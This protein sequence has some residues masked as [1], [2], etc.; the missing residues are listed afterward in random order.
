MRYI[1]GIQFDPRYLIDTHRTFAQ[2]LNRHRI[3]LTSLGTPIT[4]F[5]K[6]TDRTI[7]ISG[8]YI[9]PQKCYC[10]YDPNN[11]I[12]N[13]DPNHIVCYGTGVLPG[14][15]RYGH[16]TYV[17]TTTTENLILN[18]VN[19]EINIVNKFNGFTLNSNYLTGEIITP[20]F[21][22]NNYKETVFFRLYEVVNP[23][24]NRIEYYF[25]T[26]NGTTWTQIP[27]DRTVLNNPIVDLSVFPSSP[28]NVISNIMFRIVLRKRTINSPTPIF[29]YIKYRARTQFNLSEIDDRF[30]EIDIPATLIS[31]RLPPMILKQMESGLMVSM[32]STWWTLPESKI[33]NGDIILFLLGH[34]RGKLFV[35]HDAETRIYGKYGLPLSISFKVKLIRDETDALGIKHY[36][37]EN[38]EFIRTKIFST[39]NSESYYPSE[40]NYSILNYKNRQ[41]GSLTTW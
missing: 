28:T 24:E 17:I 14:Y 13:P 22:L 19:K 35:V 7:N 16:T 25:S 1:Q 4:V 30:R 36:L 33:K 34:M 11:R 26:D 38:N 31:H 37:S 39:F 5:H 18:N 2:A 15:E 10:T 20:N 32:E 12:R 41:P 3:I 21:P 27:V 6:E 29:N 9:Q 40:Q 8:N 23:Q